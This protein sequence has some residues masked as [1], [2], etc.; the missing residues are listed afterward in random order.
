MCAEAVGIFR[1]AN[2]CYA[3][4]SRAAVVTRPFIL[5]TPLWPIPS[6]STVDVVFSA[7]AVAVSH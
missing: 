6:R 1:Q 4:P 7:H 3:M 5:L 2:E